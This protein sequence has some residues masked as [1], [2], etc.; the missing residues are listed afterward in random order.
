MSARI[1]PVLLAVGLLVAACSG[2]DDGS[3]TTTPDP[4]D[5]TSTSST[6]STTTTTSTTV[7][8]DVTEG[9]TVV[10]ANGSGIGGSAGRMTAQLDDAGFTT[11]EPTDATTR[12]EASVVYF[13]PD[14]GAQEVAETL[15]RRLGDVEVRPVPDTIPLESGDLGDAQVL[16]VLG[17]DEADQPLSG[18][19]TTDTSGTDASGTDTSDTGGTEASATLDVGGLTVVVANANTVGG[20]AGLL[21]GELD[22]AGVSTATPVNAVVQLT[23]SVVHH[24]EA[25]GAREAA[26]TIAAALGGVEVQPLP[27][28]IP[29]ESSELDGDV[30][31]LLGDAQAGR[32]LAQLAG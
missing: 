3:A 18:D 6:S 27:D 9:A 20:S 30:L 2:S 26:E 8:A 32:T 1:A 15:G 19:A 14:E 16:L 24:S 7:P 11:A 17:S 25:D 12:V 28:E 22:D 31:V 21:T 4:V 13:S 5:V 10:V 23:A 29:T